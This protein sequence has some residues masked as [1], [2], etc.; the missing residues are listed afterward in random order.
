MLRLFSIGNV[1]TP[2]RHRWRQGWRFLRRKP[3][4]CRNVAVSRPDPLLKS[5]GAEHFDERNSLEDSTGCDVLERSNP[6]W[7][8]FT[9]KCSQ[10]P[11]FNAKAICVARSFVLRWKKYIYIYIGDRFRNFSMQNST[12]SDIGDFW[13]S[14]EWIQLS[15]WS[16]WMFTLK[17]I[18]AFDISLMST[19]LFKH[20]EK[21]VTWIF[22]CG[23]WQITVL[24]N[25][26]VRVDRFISKYASIYGIITESCKDP[27]SRSI[28]RRFISVIPKIRMSRSEISQIRND[29]QRHQP[30]QMKLY[31]ISPEFSTQK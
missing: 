22:A 14:I 5:N 4:A 29:R 20:F 12:R 26:A 30:C 13:R 16:R 2:R 9:F 10:L 8:D 31:E 1:I 6:F 3:A 19:T 15:R 25:M 27:Q 24:Y 18:G 23:H 28:P 21:T 11:G 17:N 7:V